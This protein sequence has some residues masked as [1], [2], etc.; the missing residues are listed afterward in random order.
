MKNNNK[1]IIIFLII[2]IALFVNYSIYQY[3][4]VTKFSN[5]KSAE[6]EYNDKQKELEELIKIKGNIHSV[7]KE[8]EALK[9]QVKELD[10]LILE[11]IDTAKL[12]YDFYKSCK[13]FKIT[14]E[15]IKFSIEGSDK[16][17]EEGSGE[18]GKTNDSTNNDEKEN[19][20]DITRLEIYLKIS[21]KKIDIEKYINNLDKITEGKLNVK[22]INLSTNKADDAKEEV[23][24]ANED[25]LQGQIEFYQYLKLNDEEKE[26]IKKYDF[27][28]NKVGFD[29][30]SN[31]FGN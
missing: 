25:Y 30:I 19:S 24:V 11:K 8:N 26:N 21:G 5:L 6:K 15:E 31:M 9:G 13:D 2:I 18:D 3:V 17:E 22:S 1:G 16:K 23:T 4:F 7:R 10:K 29:S 28:H 12:A 20:D 14:G 27:Y